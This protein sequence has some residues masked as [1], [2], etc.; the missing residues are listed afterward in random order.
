V[1]VFTR[2]LPQVDLVSKS[3][4]SLFSRSAPLLSRHRD[5][6]RLFCRSSLSHFGFKEEVISGMEHEELLDRMQFMFLPAVRVC[7]CALLGT[8]AFCR[9]AAV[10]RGAFAVVA[11]AH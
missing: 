5:K 3:F 9:S 11:R 4:V 6:L 7:A 2:V 1:S 10:A 8:R